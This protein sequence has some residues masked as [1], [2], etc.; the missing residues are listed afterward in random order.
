[1]LRQPRGLP[2]HVRAIVAG[3]SPSVSSP[4]AWKPILR[5]W[6]RSAAAG[7]LLPT[8]FPR[9][10][11]HSGLCLLSGFSGPGHSSLRPSCQTNRH[12]RRRAFFN[13]TPSLTFPVPVDLLPEASL[14]RVPRP[15][16]SI[17]S[18]PPGPFLARK[19]SLTWRE[20]W[21]SVL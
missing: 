2:R 15:S 4:S 5:S 20:I 3:F 16:A 13:R 17:H 19:G 11:M 18:G 9:Q 10:Q 8:G 7:L 12:K 1:M 6:F 21:W 14:P